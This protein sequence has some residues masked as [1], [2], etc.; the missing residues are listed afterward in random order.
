MDTNDQ[1]EEGEKKPTSISG[2]TRK[3]A[4]YAATV[5]GFVGVS[6]AMGTKGTIAAKLGLS[7]VV[8]GLLAVLFGAITF[9]VVFLALTV[10]SRISTKTR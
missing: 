4:E 9:A 1:V 8:G 7:V 6:G 10:K 3:W 2:I 5:G